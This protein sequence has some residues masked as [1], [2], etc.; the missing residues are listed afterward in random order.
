MI[1]SFC[2][3]FYKPPG[4]NENLSSIFAAKISIYSTEQDSTEMVL[5]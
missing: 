1:A 3:I 2:D 4:S 5:N